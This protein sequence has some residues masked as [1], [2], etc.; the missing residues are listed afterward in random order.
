MTILTTPD[1]ADLPTAASVEEFP[2]LVRLDQDWFDFKQARPRGEDVRFSTSTG[3]ALAYEIEEWDA[4]GGTA[5]IWVR[6][7]RIE[8]NARQTIRLHWGKADAASESNARAVFS[9]SN[10]FLS[11]WHLGEMVRDEVGTLESKDTGTT[12][13][14]GMIGKARHFAGKQGIFGGDKIT[15]YPS[16]DAAHTTEAW[17]RAERPNAT[18][19]GWGN[20]GGGRGSKVRMQLRSPPHL[21]VDSDFS[22][23]KGGSRLP[24]NEWIHVVHTYGGGPR[25]IYINGK[26]DA[27]AATKLD[28][29]SPARLWLGGWYHNYDFTG[30]LDEVRVSKVARPA[31]WVRL[32]FENQKPLQTLVGPL[33]QAGA[34]FAVSPAQATVPEGKSMTFTAQAGGAEKVSWALVR[35][36]Q[37]TVVAVD[38]FAF[39]FDAGRVTGDSAVT[40]RCKAVMADGV[41]ARDIPIAIKEGIAEPVFTL[42]APPSWDGRATIEVVPQVANLAAMQARGAG[43][44]KMNWSVS[45]IAIIQ[46]IAPDKL[47][48]K[49]AQN[50]GTLTVTATL[51]NGGK[52]VTQTASIAVTEPKQDAWIT[53]TPAPDERPEDGQF[54]ARDDR[55]EGTLF[56]N[57]TLAE[58]ADAVFLKVYA[59]ERLAKTETGKPGADNSYALTAKLKPGLIKYRVEF[60]AKTG[61]R[62]T[63]LHTAG[64]LVCG[65]AYLIDGQ[66][67]AEATAW[68]RQDYPFTSEWIRTFGSPESGAPGARTKLWGN[69]EARAKGGRLQVGY[70]GLDLARRLVESQKMPICILNGAVGGTRI[71]QHQRNAADPEDVTTIYGRL[72]WRVRQARLTHGIRGVLWHQGENDQ[73]ADGP[74]GGFGWESYRQYFI[75]MAAGWK[76]DYPNLQQTYVFQIWPKS[77]TMGIDGSDNRLREIQR[78]LPTA[79]SKMSLMSTLGIE[80]P[81]GC[82]YPPEGYA[83]FAR[84]IWPLVERDFYGKQFPAS[85]TPPNLQRASFASEKKDEIALEFDQPVKWDDA[86]ASQFY[87]DGEKGK[88]TSG[89]VVGK[90]VTLKLAAPSAAKTITYLDS[91]AWSQKTLLRGENGI[92]ALTFCEVPLRPIPLPR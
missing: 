72:L 55:N 61:G 57:G 32:E 52:P 85:I 47:I 33:M 19:L 91:A 14:A 51:S 59:D 41:K 71:D 78:T 35:E 73:G 26:L 76:Q 18:I 36:G 81:G 83:E 49:R 37:E 39:K 65:D 10:G 1:G 86:L 45:P 5:S 64:N 50:S 8:G 48:L 20:E 74:T 29:K 13:T 9:E 2:L 42:R 53:R 16:A 84:L 60:G 66:S 24:M 15:S 21:R 30:D 79:F 90:V 54:Y 34:A 23:I 43:A 80:P 6:I 25:R 89:G 44:L 56:Y 87:L 67:N 70:W 27:E 3:E 40:L 17:F 4:A 46:E 31:D 38:R 88:V 69:A 12:L 58:A 77:C 82:H 22:D 68:G 92:A 7:P 28:I 75:E 11:V 62:E 63:V